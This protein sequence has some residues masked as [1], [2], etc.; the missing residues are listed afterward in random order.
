M[1]E[2]KKKVEF[3]ISGMTCASCVTTIEKS[4]LNLKG[5][6]KAQVNL[7]KETAVVE[8]DSSK[9]K[10]TEIEKAIKDSGYEV[11]NEKVTLRIGGMT[12]AMCVKSI[13]NALKAVSYTH[14]TL[15]TKA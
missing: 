8:Y 4:L 9:I 1:S 2:K 15:P 13:E 3:K 7:G 10:L 11:I 5:V 14:L 12:C 6:K